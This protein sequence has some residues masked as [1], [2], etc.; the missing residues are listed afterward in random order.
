M[1]TKILQPGP[2]GPAT[3]AEAG[4]VRVKLSDLEELL[5]WTY[6]LD[7]LLLVLKAS[8]NEILSAVNSLLDIQCDWLRSMVYERDGGLSV[9]DAH[10]Q[11][12]EVSN[13]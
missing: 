3:T 11:L 8:D 2:D 5:K 12:K 6:R 4:T 7:D 1:P 9:W 13:V 10:D